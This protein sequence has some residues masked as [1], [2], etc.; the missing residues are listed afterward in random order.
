[1][2]GMALGLEQ[3][4]MGAEKVPRSQVHSPLV[5]A[6]LRGGSPAREAGHYLCPVMNRHALPGDSL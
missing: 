3:R 4:H 6:D 5:A 2:N 1:M